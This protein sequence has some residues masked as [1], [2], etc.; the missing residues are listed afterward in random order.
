MILFTEEKIT[1]ASWQT[2]GPLACKVRYCGELEI[3]WAE[4]VQDE[5]IRLFH[6]LQDCHVS[7]PI[8]PSLDIIPKAGVLMCIH[9]EQYLM[10]RLDELPP[11]ALLGIEYL[12]NIPHF[13][14][15]GVLKDIFQWKDMYLGIDTAL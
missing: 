10:F 9:L 3:L 6:S 2:L 15:L 7:I 13:N 14:L 4:L 5:L 11:K 1:V 8:E 12:I